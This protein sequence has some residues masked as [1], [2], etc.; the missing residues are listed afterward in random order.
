MKERAGVYTTQYLCESQSRLHEQANYTTHGHLGCFRLAKRTDAPRNNTVDVNIKIP[1]LEKLIDYVASGI[2]SVAGSMLAPWQ[3]SRETQAKQISAKGEAEKQEIKAKG[4]SNALQIIA[5]AQA[6]AKQ[7]LKSPDTAIQ[8]E[9]TIAETVEQRIKFQEEKRQR[10]IGSVVRLAAAELEG[11][12]VPDHE[13]DHDWVAR[14]FSDVQDVSSEELQ[15]LWAKVLSGEVERPGTMSVLSLSILKNL[16]RDTAKLFRKLCSLCISNLIETTAG[17]QVIDARALSLGDNTEG[18]ALKEYGIGFGEL[19]VLNEHG[20][21]ISEYNSW[22]DYKFNVEYIVSE[23][24]SKSRIWPFLFQDKHWTLRPTSNRDMNAEFRL[25]GVAL[26]Q[27][28]M[29][30]SR[31]VD[32]EPVDMY[33]QNL[34]NFFLEKGLIMTEIGS[35]Q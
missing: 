5:T 12:E 1:A 11:K 19:N 6:D 35:Q 20:L 16:D 22:R 7:T 21:V 15:Q 3:A 26:T 9:F 8:G 4:E 10:N 17:S 34:K 31:V 2:G 25:H 27:A 28:G 18:N 30:L 13:P 32:L 23:D 24:R 29:Q 33:T 14:F